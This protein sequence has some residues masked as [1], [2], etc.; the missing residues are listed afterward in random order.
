MSIRPL[1][2][3][4]ALLLASLPAAAQQPAPA[5]APEATATATDEIALREGRELSQLF[6]QGDTDAVWA[7]MAPSMQAAMGDAAALAKFRA[8]VTGD[9]GEEEAVLDESAAQAEGAHVYVRTSRWSKLPVPVLMQWAVDDAGKV[10]GFLV[11]PRPEAAPSPYLDYQTRSHLR[12]PF[13][14][15]WYVFWGGHDIE[16]NYHAASPG[17]RFAYDLVKRVDGS[18]HRG[19]G[20]ALEDYYCWNETILAPAAGTVL[21][22]VDGLPDQAIGSRDTSHIAG[23]HV[24]LDLGNGEYA[25]LAH[26]RQGSVVVKA[27]DKV[28]PGDE[29]GRCGNSGNTSEPHLHF[30]LQDAPVFGQGNGLPA[31]F[32]H[33]TADGKAVERGEPVQG[34]VIAPT[35]G[36]TPR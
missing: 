22:A 34:Q 17:Q 3:A 13:D 24:M 6:L 31:F 20:R 28:N 26:M 9:L 7:R 8:Q 29:L 30:H 18:S 25:L 15:Q 35:G 14:G 19:D 33:Y 12:L 23:N 27:G 21:E 10:A 32:E 1:S 11:Q 36:T 16:Q 2:A 4:L 5:P